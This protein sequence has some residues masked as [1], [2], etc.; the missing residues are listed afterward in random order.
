MYIITACLSLK[1]LKYILATGLISAISH[2]YRIE[3]F[4]ITRTVR[5]ATYLL[6]LQSILC[7][8]GR[9]LGAQYKIH[10]L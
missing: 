8:I 5:G 6:K 10:L 3:S 1:H 4:I 9:F 7:E 2:K